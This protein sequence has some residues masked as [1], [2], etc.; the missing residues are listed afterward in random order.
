[1]PP[2]DKGRWRRRRR[3]GNLRDASDVMGS[4]NDHVDILT[5]VLKR[6]DWRS[7]FSAACVCRLWSS[8]VRGDDALWEELCFRHVSPRPP[9][10]VLRPV[11][12]AL[13]GYKQ[14]YMVYIRPVVFRTV[15]SAVDHQRRVW[16]AD[17][18]QLYLSL[19]CVD[20]YE[21]LAGGN[22]GT[23]SDDASASSSSSSLAFLLSSP[24]N[25]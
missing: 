20:Y 17:E 11:A 21:R 9:S 22:G 19:F 16:T 2:T 8:I 5:E 7:L 18:V 6:L 14:L 13:G 4:I 15:G 10:W 1:M 23:E 24:V 12:G 25:V 3:K